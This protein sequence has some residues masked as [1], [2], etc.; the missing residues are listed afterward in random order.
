MEGHRL[1]T[2]LVA[3]ERTLRLLLAEL[4]NDEGGSSSVW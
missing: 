1:D 4:M 2:T 3:A